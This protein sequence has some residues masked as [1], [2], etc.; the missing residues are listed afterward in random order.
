MVCVYVRFSIYV[1]TNQATQ[2][3]EVNEKNLKVNIRARESRFYT[4]N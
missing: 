1:F 4:C 3:Y 2:T